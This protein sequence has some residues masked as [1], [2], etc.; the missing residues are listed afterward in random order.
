MLPAPRADTHRALTCAHQSVSYNT[1]LFNMIYFVFYREPRTALKGDFIMRNATDHSEGTI[2]TFVEGD[3]CA[4][5]AADDR[6]ASPG[7]LTDAYQRAVQ[8]LRDVRHMLPPDGVAIVDAA[9]DGTPLLAPQGFTHEH[10]P[11]NPEQADEFLERA[12]WN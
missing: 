5:G 4:A 1:Y 7:E 6:A 12:L 10:K 3:R 11:L 2:L 8:A 9:L